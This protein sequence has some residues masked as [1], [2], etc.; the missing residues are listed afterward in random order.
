M[1]YLQCARDERRENDRNGRARLSRTECRWWKGGEGGVQLMNCSLKWGMTVGK[2]LPFYV[3]RI[4]LQ[5]KTR[6]YCYSVRDRYYTDTYSKSVAAFS[7]PPPFY[8]KSFFSLLIRKNNAALHG[9]TRTYKI[10]SN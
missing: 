2:R 10:Q 5:F 6:K 1:I 4:S 9:Y 7:P 8:A 3:I